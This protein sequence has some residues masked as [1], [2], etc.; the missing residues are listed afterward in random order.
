MSF[1][2]FTHIGH[3]NSI[4]LEGRLRV[5]ESNIGAPYAVPQ[6]PSGLDAGPRVVWLT[7]LDALPLDEDTHPLYLGLYPEKRR[8]RFEV[9]VPAIRW[10]DWA[11]AARMDPDW[12]E[13]FVRSAGGPD[14]VEHW[15]VFPAPVREPR[16]VSVRD[17]V[18][19]VDVIGGAA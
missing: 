12:R 16:W 3:L 4:I 7:D 19:D 2:H 15:Y 6:G 9:D 18:R 1:F 10:L 8:I 14:V 11:P 17:V 13:T 5:T